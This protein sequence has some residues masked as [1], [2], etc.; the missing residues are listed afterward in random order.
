MTV[1]KK[2]HVSS[3]ALFPQRLNLLCIFYLY[4]KNEFHNPEKH[5]K[6]LNLGS[7]FFALEY[8]QSKQKT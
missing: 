1:Y 4:F 3:A 8:V 6:F 5:W 2:V 7:S